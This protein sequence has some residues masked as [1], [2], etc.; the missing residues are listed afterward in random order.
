[1][2][3][4]R[5]RYSILYESPQ[6][7]LF[8]IYGNSGQPSMFRSKRRAVRRM[9]RIRKSGTLPKGGVLRIVDRLNQQWG[10]AE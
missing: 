5:Q 2:A 9:A 1:M 10:T 8:W 6:G 7:G 4:R 3:D